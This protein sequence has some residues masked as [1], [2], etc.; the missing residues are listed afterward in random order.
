MIRGKLK[1]D[2]VLP[3][4]NEENILERTVE[5]L[6]AF[7]ENDLTYDWNIIIADNASNDNTLRKAVELS[8]RFERVKWL[9]LPRKGK[10][11]A[12]R[13]AWLESDADIVS[14]M[15]VDLST[16]LEA[17][18]K[19]IEAILNG[20]DL[21]VG[22]RVLPNSKTVRSLKREFISCCYNILIRVLFSTHFTDAHCGFKV[23]NVK[24]V[25]EIVPLIE[26][27][28]YFFDAELLILTAKRG[29]KIKDIAVSWVEDK[30]TKARIAKDAYDDI[31]GLLRLRCRS[32][33][34]KSRDQ[35]RQR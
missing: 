20:Y 3:V 7:L 2:V 6:Y 11:R 22:S 25:K 16:G 32:K 26:D 31:K 33:L 34:L 29:Y 28:E 8:T 27:E 18:P 5:T 4:Y 10:G 15:D 13:K 1:V 24:A 19:A 12:L 35:F 30:D 21:A 17:L 23:A 9:H 14:Y